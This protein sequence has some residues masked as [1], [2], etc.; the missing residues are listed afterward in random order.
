V[1]PQTGQQLYLTKDKGAVP[2]SATSPSDRSFIGSAQPDF[3]YGMTNVVTYKNFDLTV[4]LQGS[5]GNDIFNGARVETEGM[6]DS[7]NQSTAILNRWRNPGDITDIP[8]V[9]LAS[10]D[11]TVISTRFV[12]NGSYLRFKTITLAYRINQKWLDNIGIAGASVYVSGQ[13]LI[14]VTKY[15]GFDPEV[16]TYGGVGNTTDNRNVS[17]GVDYGAYPQSKTFLFGINL[18]L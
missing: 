5:Q 4:F 10:N 14:T 8:G 1:D 2:Y 13:N 9:S 11:N 17:L 15:K 7:R 3:V 12:E 16:S 18:S 6:K